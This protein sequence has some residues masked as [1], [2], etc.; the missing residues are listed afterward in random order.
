MARSPRKA[1][2]GVYKFEADKLIIAT[3]QGGP[4]PAH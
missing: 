3:R 1:E 2:F 4:P